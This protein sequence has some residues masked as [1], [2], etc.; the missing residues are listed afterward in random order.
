MTLRRNAGTLFLLA[1]FA[2]PTAALA[3]IAPFKVNSTDDTAGQD[4][5]NPANTC[6]GRSLRPPLSASPRRSI[7]LASRTPG[8]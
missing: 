4:C 2:V 1:A 8:T 3:T 6:A 7:S 5:T